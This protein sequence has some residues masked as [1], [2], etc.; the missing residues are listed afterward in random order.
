MIVTV[1]HLAVGGNPIDIIAG[2][3]PRTRPP[4]LL[5]SY[6]YR[7]TWERVRAEVTYRHWILDS[8]A[9]SAHTQG[10]PIDLAEFTD[11]AARELER[12]KTLIAVFGLDVIGDHERSIRNIEE[13]RR[14]GID[15]IPTVHASAPTEAIQELRRY[16]RVALG[17]MVGMK[18]PQQ[19]K[20]CEQAFALLWPKWIHAFGI[21]YE[22][23]LLRFPFSS[24][25]A[26]SWTYAPRAFGQWIGF[27]GK[28]RA[29]PLRQ[30]QVGEGRAM[31]IGIEVDWHLRLEQRISK[32]WAQELAQLGGWP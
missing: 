12:D 8:G 5:V 1:M 6:W 14:Q 29:L 32:R 2:L 22:P 10:K 7:K 27:S 26:S 19:W 3:R 15:A 25:D 28:Q 23:T 13:M 21:S 20:F 18:R 30:A 4:A 31:P 24:C 17:G 9:F 11:Y 16:P